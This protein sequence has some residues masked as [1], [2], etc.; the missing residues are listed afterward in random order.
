[1]SL[2]VPQHDASRSVTNVHKICH[3]EPQSPVSRAGQA[4][5][6][7]ESGGKEGGV[8]DISI[9]IDIDV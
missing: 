2:T 1:M 5:Q 3:R 8:F 7:Q 4:Q 9:N 6:Q